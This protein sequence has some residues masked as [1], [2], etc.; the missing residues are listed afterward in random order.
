[1]SLAIDVEDA[2][3]DAVPGLEALTHRAVAATFAAM[4]RDLAQFDISILFTGDAAV[5]AIN[6]QWRGKDYATTVLSFPAEAMPVPAGEARPLGDIVLAAG[7]VAREAA[8]Q[9]K[10]L[11]DHAGHLII[12]GLLHLLGF[13]HETEAEA[14]AMERLE[15][16][17][18]K[19]LD[20]S[21]P[22]ERQ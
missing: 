5:A 18:L 15:A 7:V 4:T 21:D 10:T 12:H 3:W 20:I 13:D 8:E 22:Y 1:M 17:I 6:K 9:G 16:A 11:P 14:E 2:A 19:G